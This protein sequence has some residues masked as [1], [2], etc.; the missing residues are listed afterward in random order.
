MDEELEISQEEQQTAEVSKTEKVFTEQDVQRI[1]QDRLQREKAS[2]KRKIDEYEAHLKDY[3][4]QIEA[5]ENIIKSF[6][7]KEIENQP[8]PIKKLLSKLSVIDQWEYLTSGL[9][10]KKFIPSTP[11][12]VEE[13]EKRPKQKFKLFI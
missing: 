10:E 11:K 5:Y 4:S 8:E 12:P 7:E 2:A 9:S 13:E 6:V 3:Q 1:V